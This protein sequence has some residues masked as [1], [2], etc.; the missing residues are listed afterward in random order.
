[1]VHTRGWGEGETEGEVPCPKIVV[2]M[3]DPPYNIWM[4][5]LGILFLS[6]RGA[7]G[8]GPGFLTRKKSLLRQANGV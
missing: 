2:R 7:P 1:M 6:E 3:R 8:Q 5:L 4:P